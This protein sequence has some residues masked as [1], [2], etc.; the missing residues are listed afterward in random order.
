MGDSDFYFT[1]SHRGAYCPAG[2]AL[3]GLSDLLEGGLR[4]GVFIPIQEA[5]DGTFARIA[6]PPAEN[7]ITGP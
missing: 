5:D 6:L 7:G 3:C 1:V 2:L 4:D